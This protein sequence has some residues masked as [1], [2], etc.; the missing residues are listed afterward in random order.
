MFCKRYIPLLIFFL[1]SVAFTCNKKTTD[2]NKKLD[3]TTVSNEG[4]ETPRNRGTQAR[5]TDINDIYG[6]WTVAS[7]T[8]K[9]AGNVD[10]LQYY[11]LTITQKDIRLPL[12][13]NVC[14]GIYTLKQNNLDLNMIACTEACCDSEEAQAI[15]H[16]FSGMVSFRKEDQTLYLNNGKASMELF[17][18]EFMLPETRW[19]AIAYRPKGEETKP[20]LF[21][22]AYV[23]VFKDIRL[24]LELDANTCST[25]Y[26]YNEKTIRIPNP[27]GCSKVCC[28]SKDG[29]LLRDMLKGRLNYQIEGNNLT[30][31]TEKN[32]IS[33]VMDD[34]QLKD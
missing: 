3:E 23:L 20:I 19:K 11:H 34:S 5:P 26:S 17:Q 1:C 22:K 13:V 15:S 21:S 14:S 6:T 29:L 32:I 16:F 2:A 25:A 28:D 4:T 27:M 12:D 33:F 9:D 24:M 8:R 7:L 31:T 18:P 10:P 30:V